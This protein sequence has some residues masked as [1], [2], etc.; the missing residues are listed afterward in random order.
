MIVLPSRGRPDSLRQFFETSRPVVKGVVLLDSDDAHQYATVP[1]PPHWSVLIGPRIAYVA[2]M[3]VAFCTY[4][5]EPF[6][7]YGGDD[8]RCP[9]PGWDTTLA[10]AA[11]TTHIAYGND[12]IN[13]ERTCCLP[14]LGGDLV[15]R[16]GWLAYPALGHLFCDTIWHDLGRALGVLHYFPNIVTEHLHWS[17][18]KMAVDRTAQERRTQGDRVAYQDFLA[19]HFEETVT[20]CK[21]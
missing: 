11:G 2:L 19:Q 7:A 1:I 20:R 13:G 18:G 16:A 3:N 17:T 10:Q 14:F 9:T 4:P 15:R 12:L 5:D 8:V 21:A 6:Y